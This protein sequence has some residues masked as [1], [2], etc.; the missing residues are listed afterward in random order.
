VATERF[1]DYESLHPDEPLSP[2]VRPDAERGVAAGRRRTVELRRAV[3]VSQNASH[4]AIGH[5]RPRRA[6]DP[7]ESHCEADVLLR[8]LGGQMEA[9]RLAAKLHDARDE[10]D[11]A[12]SSIALGATRTGNESRRLG[13]AVGSA[14]RCGSAAVMSPTAD[15]A[16]SRL[17][18]SSGSLASP[19]IRA[20][21]R[22]SRGRVQTAGG[23]DAVPTLLARSANSA[24]RAATV[25]CSDS[26]RPGR[27]G[28]EGETWRGDTQARA[29]L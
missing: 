18:R 13:A 2:D 9:V 16:A 29:A 15:E 14:S 8:G 1:N 23:E 24:R 27:G 5:G 7:P 19:G 25:A 3:E 21:A 10:L 11:L 12:V 4:R 28:A 6:P 20:L 26:Y 22:L 17:D